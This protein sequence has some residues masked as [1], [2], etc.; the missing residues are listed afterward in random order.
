MNLMEKEICRVIL[1]ASTRFACK[2]QYVRYENFTTIFIASLK[3]A[4]NTR[5]KYETYTRI[6]HET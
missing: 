6:K 4:C 5:I 3:K 1:Q 2:W